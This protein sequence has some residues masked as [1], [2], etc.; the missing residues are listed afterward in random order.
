MA[1]K[2]V[3]EDGDHQYYGRSWWQISFGRIGCIL[4]V[5]VIVCVVIPIMYAKWIKPTGAIRTLDNPKASK[6]DKLDALRLIRETKFALG[7]D[8]AALRLKDAKENLEVRGE[9]ARTVAAFGG[10]AQK[11]L[12]IV[13]D[14]PAP[15]ELRMAILN[16]LGNESRQLVEDTASITN[17]EEFRD[18]C[19]EWLEK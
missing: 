15:I 10:K 11:V 19:H 6:K 8:A 13:F 5:I 12:Q 16:H 1:R 17:D 18:A 4:A 9:A 2:V 14:S 7:F 3:F